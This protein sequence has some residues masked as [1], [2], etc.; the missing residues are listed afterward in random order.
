MLC[1][2][3]CLHLSDHLSAELINKLRIFVKFYLGQETADYIL[4]ITSVQIQNVISS[5]PICSSVTRLFYYYYIALC[6]HSNTN[7]FSEEPDFNSL[8][9]FDTT[10]NS[11]WWKFGLFECSPV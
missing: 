6:Q 2:L 11:L 9:Q 4:R 5:L 3:F 8:Q 7:G 10:K 1:V